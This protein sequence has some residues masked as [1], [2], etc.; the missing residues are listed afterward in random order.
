MIRRSAATAAAACTS[1]SGFVRTLARGRGRGPR[2][3]PGR[4]REPR[5]ELPQPQQPPQRPAA[6]TTAEASPAADTTSATPI[7]ASDKRLAW[8]SLV[9]GS[10][11]ICSLTLNKWEVEK[12]WEVMWEKP[13][14]RIRPIRPPASD[15]AQGGTQP[16]YIGRCSGWPGRSGLFSTYPTAGSRSCRQRWR[17]SGGQESTRRPLELELSE[18]HR[19]RRPEPCCVPRARDLCSG[20]PKIPRFANLAKKKVK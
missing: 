16:R 9:F 18:Q 7:N 2:G 8:A 5:Q 11:A 19:S 10:L 17:R 4:R 14:K 3:A 6:T 12:R 20:V 15:Q 13:P 1:S